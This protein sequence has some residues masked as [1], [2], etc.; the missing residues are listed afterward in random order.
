M[1]L[2]S[3][4]GSTETLA[5]VDGL[6]LTI[7]IGHGRGTIIILTGSILGSGI[8]STVLLASLGEGG[9]A[10]VSEETTVAVS[11]GELDESVISPAGSPGVLDQDK[12]GGVSHGSDSMVG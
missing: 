1:A 11:S 9:V 3:Q 8:R 4:S 10:G 2:S 5:A 6:V 7:G 12:L